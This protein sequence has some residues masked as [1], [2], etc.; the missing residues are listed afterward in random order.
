MVKVLSFYI[1]NLSDTDIFILIMSVNE[2]DNILPVVNLVKS[3]F[4]R[5]SHNDLNSTQFYFV[6][7]DV[8]LLGYLMIVC[9]FDH[10]YMLGEC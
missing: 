9:T 5:R 1:N 3:A 10:T 4:D 8:S 7:F 6:I 2:Y